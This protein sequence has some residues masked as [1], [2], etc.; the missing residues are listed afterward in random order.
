MQ[1]ADFDPAKVADVTAE[2]WF[3]LDPE[4][5]E[6]VLQAVDQQG[7]FLHEIVVNGD[8]T[9]TLKMGGISVAT[10]PVSRVLR[11][12]ISPPAQA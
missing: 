6:E 7:G 4:Q 1:G 9:V 12:P 3:Q 11:S 8:G 5:R 2:G 10:V